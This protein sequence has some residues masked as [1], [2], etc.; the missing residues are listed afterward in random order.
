MRSGQLVK[1]KPYSMVDYGTPEGS[2]SFQV[3]DNNCFGVVLDFYSYSGTYEVLLDGEVCFN[4]YPDS[5][6]AV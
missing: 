5:L 1:L 2:M 3:E 6:E 4:V